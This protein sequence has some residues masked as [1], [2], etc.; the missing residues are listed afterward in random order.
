MCML[1]DAMAKDVAKNKKKAEGVADLKRELARK[2]NYLLR[3]EKEL[4]EKEERLKQKEEELLKLKKYLEE[5]EER[6]LGIEKL[7]KATS[8]AKNLPSYIID[9]L[10]RNNMQAI[11]L[12]EVKEILMFTFTDQEFEEVI[13]G[14]QIIGENKTSFI[15]K[16]NNSLNYHHLKDNIHK[17]FFKKV[18]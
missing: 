16:V 12:D 9:L 15:R 8:L 10:N 14:W 4:K 6:L 7:I 5:K 13:E 1:I 3:K 18:N 2:E 17:G 11:S